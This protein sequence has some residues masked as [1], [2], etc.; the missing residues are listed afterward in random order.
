[1]EKYPEANLDQYKFCIG[2]YGWQ[3]IPVIFV[4]S[5]TVL[6]GC[7]WHKLDGLFTVE[8]EYALLHEAGHAHNHQKWSFL[9]NGEMSTLSILGI[10]VAVVAGSSH[11]YNENYFELQK[12]LKY[13]PFAKDDLSGH[14]IGG[15]TA[16]GLLA[17]PIVACYAM[18]KGQYITW[19]KL[20]ERYADKFANR[21]ADAQALKGGITFFN[22]LACYEEKITLKDIVK[23]LV[24]KPN[25]Y[26]EYYPGFTGK[27]RAILYVYQNYLYKISEISNYLCKEHPYS[28]SRANEAR[29]ALKVRFGQEED[30]KINKEYIIA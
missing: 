27:I 9:Y 30:N 16:V 24:K 18:A 17:A 15:T 29:K 6:I 23:M 19:R 1:M 11:A 3:M 5:K 14:L 20:D 26:F 2:G 21:Y 12:K 25:F 22:N 7:P 28:D 8:D 10:A 13:D 4:E